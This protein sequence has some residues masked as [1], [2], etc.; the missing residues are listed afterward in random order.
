[1]KINTVIYLVLLFCYLFFIQDAKA[2][3]IHFNN[4]IYTLKTSRFSHINKGYENE[5][6]LQNEKKENWSKIIG[7]YYYPEIKDPIKFA[8]N[9]DKEIETKST[10]ILL[11]F[12][13]NKKQNKAVLS[14]ID[15]GEVDGR[16][17]FEHNIYKYEPH[18]KKGMMI[19]KYAKRFFAST[20]KEAT[21]IGQEIKAVNDDLIE[22]II[23]SPIP[24][25]IE[26]E[27]D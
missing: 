19:L 20:N 21:Q 6:L 23:I 11:K 8:E 2:E 17:Y 16:A 22:Q 7:I 10:V 15:S 3:N 12:I 4:D 13:A 27:I 5:Y 9:A 18:P 24:P 14:F 26:T 1:M 25:V